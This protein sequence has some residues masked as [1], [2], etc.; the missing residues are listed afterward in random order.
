MGYDEAL[1]HLGEFGR[2]QKRIYFLLCIPTISCALHKLAWV[3]LGARVKHRCK[4]PYEA[5]NATFDLG[6]DLN[7][8]IPWDKS[9]HGPAKCL[10]YD[11]N[12][13][14]EYFQEGIPANK[15]VECHSWV[16]DT[17]VYESSAVMEWNLVCE[18]AWLRATADSI[19]MSGVLLGSLIFGDLSDRFGRKPTFFFSLVLQVIAGIFAAFAPDYISFVIARMIVGATTSGVFLVAYVIGVE[20]VGPSA[21]LFTGVFCQY[22]FSFGFLVTA[23]FSYFVKDWRML[24]VAL[25]VPGIIFFSYWWIIP[26][27]VRWLLT[28][29]R[30]DE[31][32]VLLNKAAKENKVEIPE[33]LFK[34]ITEEKVDEEDNTQRHSLLDL[35]RYPNLRKKTLYIFFN[36][37]VISGSYYGLSWNTSN[38]G[39][40][41]YLNFIISGVVEIPGYTFALLTLNRWG[42]KLPLCGSMLIGGLALLLTLAVPEDMNWLFIS[43]AMF[44]KLAI[45]AA[46]GAI[47]IFSAEQFPTV[48]RNVAIGASSMSARVGGILAPF[49]NLLANYWKPMPFIIFGALAFAGGLMVLLLPETMKKQLPETIE[50]GENFGKKIVEDQ[51]EATAL[52]PRH[53]NDSDVGDK[54]TV[55]A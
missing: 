47:Y 18:D 50:D 55:T 22:F 48:I 10:R 32:K 24:Q 28:K 15:S 35:F 34:K 1:K 13:T 51:E 36:W 37:M 46:Y 20:L 40:N 2:Y 27:S 52:S 42:R 45:T 53:K 29:G 9:H 12:F 17:S 6:S 31:V 4:L 43:L 26:E 38:L 21:R 25:T 16:Y 19:F 14:S 7:M 44:G 23:F 30:V 3:F 49:I 39:G 54:K 41:D 8:T 33:E 5:D 11:A